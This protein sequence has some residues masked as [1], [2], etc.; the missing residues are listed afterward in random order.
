MVYYVRFLKPP[1]LDVS[2]GT[3]RALVTVTTD[4]GDEFYPGH[5]T[6]YAVAVTLG[7]DQHWNSQLQRVDWKYGMRT[8][9][10]EVQDMKHCP[11]ELLQ[12]VVTTQPTLVA[13]KILLSDIPEVLSVRSDSFGRGRG[14]E[15]RQ[16]DSRTERRYMTSNGQGRIIHEEMG[17]SI[18]RHIW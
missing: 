5:L 18:A 9:W 7:E 1:K 10:I 12:L 16:A 3:V 4:L 17:E 2:K 14:W 6:L 11:Q 13:D 15:K 8:A